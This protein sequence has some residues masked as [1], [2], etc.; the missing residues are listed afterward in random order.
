MLRVLKYG[1]QAATALCSRKIRLVLLLACL[2]VLGL[3]LAAVAQTETGRI[4]G[5]VTDATG[6]FVPGATIT[7]KGVATGVTRDTVSD[8]AGRYADLAILVREL[9]AVPAARP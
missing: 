1:R 2:L 8:A 9:T 4:T 6:A 3:P 7:L 5:T